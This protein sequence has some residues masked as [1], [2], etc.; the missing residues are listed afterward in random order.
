MKDELIF[1]ESFKWDERITEKEHEDLYKGI[2][3]GISGA[4]IFMILLSV[5][6]LL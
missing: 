6:S 2:L 4:M 1:K 5:V 3:Y